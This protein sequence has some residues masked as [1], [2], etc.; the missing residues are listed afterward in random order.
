MYALAKAASKHVTVVQSGEG[1]DEILAGYLTHKIIH[2]G[3]KYNQLVP[4][5][6]QNQIKNII[7]IVPPKLINNIF[8]YPGELGESG[9][10]R[11]I[12]FLEMLQIYSKEFN[13]QFLISLFTNQ[14]ISQLTKKSSKNINIF[15]N[16]NYTKDSL[17]SVLN[18]QFNDWLPDDILSKLDKITMANSLEGRV[19]F[20]D[21]K[22]VE[23]LISL[24]SQYKLHFGR[25]KILLRNYLKQTSTF[26]TSFKKKVPFYIPIDRYLSSEPLNSM[27][28]DLNENQLIKRYFKLEIYRKSFKSEK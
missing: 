18:F 5:I 12:D 11:L 13:F 27:I 28:K 23:F 22:L 19:P 8:D 3:S 14:E 15:K 21:H 26:Q 24:P 10:N 9:K 25:N 4:E 7:K 17:N 1:A 20:M 16:E 6:V 2:Y